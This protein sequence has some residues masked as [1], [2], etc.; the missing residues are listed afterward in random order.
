MELTIAQKSFIA[1]ALIVAWLAFGRAEMPSPEPDP[2]PPS[3]VAASFADAFRANSQR[4]RH[5]HEDA[6][7][8][9][10]ICLATSRMIAWDGS[11]KAGAPRLTTS[12]HV[13]D[14]RIVIRDFVAEGGSF[15]AAYPELGPAIGEFLSQRISEETDANAPLSNQDRK[16]WS[17]ALEELH[18]ALHDAAKTL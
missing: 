12:A 18:D 1:A 6:V 16:A 3:P 9:A 11:R 8:L 14:L 7:E 5:W 2:E 15:T 13:E 4:K 10:D 17:K